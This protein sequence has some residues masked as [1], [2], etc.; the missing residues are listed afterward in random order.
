MADTALPLPKE[1]VSARLN[2]R[3][4]RSSRGP[5]PVTNPNRRLIGVHTPETEQERG[6]DAL[7]KSVDEK[8]LKYPIVMDKDGQTWKTWGNRW[9][10]ST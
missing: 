10:P 2:G 8:K 5:S 4:I 3:G 6:I 1:V 7:R 9:W